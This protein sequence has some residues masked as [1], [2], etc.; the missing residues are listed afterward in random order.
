MNLKDKLDELEARISED[1]GARLVDYWDE[2]GLWLRAN[3]EIEFLYRQMKPL[4]RVARAAEQVR[5]S[6]LG[7]EDWVE[8]QKSLE[9]LEGDQ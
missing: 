1:P 4:V 5:D 2:D 3:A 9:A 7:D 6:D 8:L